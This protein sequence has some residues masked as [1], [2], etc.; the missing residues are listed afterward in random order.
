MQLHGFARNVDWRLAAASDGAGS[1]SVTLV[2]TDSEYTRAMWPHTFQVGC[3]AC[4]NRWNGC[5]PVDGGFVVPPACRCAAVLMKPVAAQCPLLAPTHLAWVQAPSPPTHPP[6][7][8]LFPQPT[9]PPS[10]QAEYV[11]TLEGDQLATRLKVTNT[12]DKPLEF[13]ASLH[14]W[15]T[16]L[17]PGPWWGLR[18]SITVLPASRAVQAGQEVGLPE[19]PGWSCCAHSGC[20]PATF[21][22][23]S[24]I[25]P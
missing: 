13:T 18:S 6:T 3:R 16:P 2:L 9:L 4:V 17:A 12:G 22:A 23:G 21:L 25:A 10:R 1:P 5:L 24:R 19:A 8:F 15:A 7:H 11:V 20:L 14:R